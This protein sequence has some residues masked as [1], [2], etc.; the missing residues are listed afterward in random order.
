[1]ADR[2]DG[3]EVR[4][5]MGFAPEL[6]RGESRFAHHKTPPLHHFFQL[7]FRFVVLLSNRRRYGKNPVLPC[8][9][10]P[11]SGAQTVHFLGSIFSS[12]QP[13]TC[14]DLTGGGAA[15]S[16]LHPA[17]SITGNYMRRKLNFFPGAGVSFFQGHTDGRHCRLVLLLSHQPSTCNGRRSSP[18][19][20]V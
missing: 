9:S 7:S 15:L 8:V 17:G 16:Q 20:T 6:L 14:R 1:M 10:F 11:P 3:D 13:S 2:I 5:R 12:H 18:H 19:L 4:A